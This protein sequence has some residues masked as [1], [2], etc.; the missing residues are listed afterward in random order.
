MN[1]N[2]NLKTKENE[3]NNNSWYNYY[4]QYGDCTN[5]LVSSVFTSIARSESV[6]RRMVL[7]IPCDYAEDYNDICYI[8]AYVYNNYENL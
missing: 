3:K 7:H 6:W 1:L 5:H 8:I 2:I 4:N